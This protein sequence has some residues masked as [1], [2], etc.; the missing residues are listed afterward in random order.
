[1]SYIVKLR[2]GTSYKLSDEDGTSLREH[3]ESAKHPFPAEL[4][5]GTV[6]STQI[7]SIMREQKTEADWVPT[8]IDESR[9]VEASNRCRGEYS[10]QSEINN[11]A[12]FEGGKVS[13]LNPRG[14]KWQKLIKSTKWREM[15]RLRLRTQGQ[16]W[17]DYRANECS[18]EAEYLSTRQRHPS[19]AE[20]E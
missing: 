13:E 20:K 4:G 18:C 17:C 16:R 6:L 1:M 14:L 8:N 5:E 2:D 10:I 15:V 3:W 9:W 7:I 11:I 12:R 19:W